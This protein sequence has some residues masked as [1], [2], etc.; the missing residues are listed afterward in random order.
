MC[1]RFRH[2]MKPM[3]KTLA[4]TTEKSILSTDLVRDDTIDVVGRYINK[5]IHLEAEDVITDGTIKARFLVQKVS[6]YICVKRIKYPINLSF[7][8]V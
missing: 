8:V 2:T 3:I 7:D 1:N 4:T 5:E 6:E